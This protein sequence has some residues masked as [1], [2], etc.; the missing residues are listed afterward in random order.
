MVEDMEQAI[1][2]WIKA[3]EM[4]GKAC[5]PKPLEERRAIREERKRLY[6]EANVLAGGN[7]ALLAELTRRKLISWAF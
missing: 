6:T 3:G 7:R 5:W 2:T 4:H 1:A